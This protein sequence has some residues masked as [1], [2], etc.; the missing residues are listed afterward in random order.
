MQNNSALF[1]LLAI[2]N[3]MTISTGYHCSHTKNLRQEVISQSVLIV[4]NCVAQYDIVTN[5]FPGY[6]QDLFLLKENVW[7]EK[8]LG[9]K[10][11]CYILC[12][13]NY[14]QWNEKNL[15]KVAFKKFE[16]M[17][18][19]YFFLQKPPSANFN[20]FILEFIVPCVG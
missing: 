18:S 19:H 8:S 14:S 12:D 1:L 5:C 2:D 7:A 16:V 13:T 15:W 9:R 6:R 4:K 10:F 3:Y 11:F 20:W 17:L